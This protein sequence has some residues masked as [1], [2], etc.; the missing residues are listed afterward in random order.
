VDDR[1]DYGVTKGAVIV[2]A[3]NATVLAKLYP[4]LQEKNGKPVAMVTA[5]GKGKIGVIG[6]N[7][8]TQYNDAV[9]YQHRDLIRN[10]TAMLYN[11]IARVESVDG[12]CEIVCLSVRGKLML[13]I[14]NAGGGHRDPLLSTENYIPPLENVVISLCD[15]IGVETVVLRPEGKP[16]DVSKCNGRNYFR[17]PKVDIHSIAEINTKSPLVK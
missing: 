3:E 4:S 15:D 16:L 17:I 6:F 8:G 11:P 13:Q 12:I 7:I 10:M 14:V 2:N 1:A 5:Y 9:Q